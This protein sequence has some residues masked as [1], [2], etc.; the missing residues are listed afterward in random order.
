MYLIPEVENY[1]A[2]FCVI[3]TLFELN[4][5]TKLQICENARKGRFNVLQISV[6]IS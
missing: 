5:S 1:M 3:L 4:L 2:A 6:F